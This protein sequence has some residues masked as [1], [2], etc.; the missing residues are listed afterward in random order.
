MILNQ[1]GM[2]LIVFERHIQ[3][4]E[5]L[6][7]FMGL[8]PSHQWVAIFADFSAEMALEWIVEARW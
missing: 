4:K 6:R 5:I 7:I 3:I 8:A 2:Y 1:L